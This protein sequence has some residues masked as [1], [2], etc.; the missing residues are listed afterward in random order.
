MEINR[1][2]ST[3]EQNFTNLKSEQES[4]KRRIAED[5]NRIALMTQEIER[6]NQVLKTKSDESKHYQTE[7]QKYAIEL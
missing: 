3:Y 1:K 7:I 4:Y 5:E 6:L 2:V